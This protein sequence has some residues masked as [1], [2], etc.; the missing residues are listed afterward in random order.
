[1]D[2]FIY[3]L[4]IVYLIL[5]VCFAYVYVCAPFVGLSAPEGQKKQLTLE[6]QT[7]L[8]YRAGARNQSCVLW[9]SSKCS[10]SL[11]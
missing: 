1:M 2:Y 5:P 10:K 6:L 4:F 11:Q 8:S 7:I 9:K 3:W